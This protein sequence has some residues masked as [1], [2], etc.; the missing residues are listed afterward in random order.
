MTTSAAAE[1]TPW[2]HH[3]WPW[4]IVVLMTVSIIGSLVTVAIAYRYRD[5]DVRTLPP[6]D[7]RHQSA[8]MLEASPAEPR[9]PESGG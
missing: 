1:G 2:Y 9:A 6:T 7:V 3:F 4:F 5:I 8:P